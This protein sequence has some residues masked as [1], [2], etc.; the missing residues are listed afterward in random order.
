M[1]VII[2]APP[3]H[4]ISKSGADLRLRT[5]G[6]GMLLSWENEAPSDIVEQWHADPDLE[7]WQKPGQPAGLRALLCGCSDFPAFKEIC[8]VL[9]M[10]GQMVSHIVD[11][12]PVC[13]LRL[14]GPERDA[15]YLTLRLRPLAERLGTDIA[16]TALPPSPSLS[17]PGCLFMD[18]DSTLIRCECI[19]ELGDYL[20]VRDEIASITLR[21]MEGELDFAASLRERV[22]LLRGLRAEVLEQ[23]YRER[24]RL[25]EGAEQLVSTLAEHGWKVG[26]VSGGFTFFT[27]RLK[28]RLHLDFAAGNTLEIS[29]G[30]LTGRTLGPVADAMS[31]REALIRQAGMWHIPMSQTVAVGDGANDIP[32]LEAAALGIAFHAKP[33]VREVAPYSISHGGLDRILSLLQDD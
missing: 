18:M 16:I 14:A 29:N 10:E 26:L 15:K 6:N 32:M 23:V 5:P 24:I 17:Q 31:K 30:R 9:A 11:R 20:G 13:A 1:S 2:L 12:G 22:K 28:E 25:T 3:N 27:D 19:D 21:A 4:P 7:V 8:T 33:K